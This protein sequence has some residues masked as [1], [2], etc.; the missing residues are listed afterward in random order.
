MAIHPFRTN[1]SATADASGQRTVPVVRLLLAGFLLAGC[2]IISAPVARASAQDAPGKVATLRR[3]A[4]SLA[5]T[6]R[7]HRAASA[8]YLQLGLALESTENIRPA[9]AAYREG[10][11][12]AERARDTLALAD[13]EH[14]VGLL[15]WRTNLYDSALVHLE[16][17]KRYRVARN[18]QRGLSAEYNSIGA[19][20]Y[21]LGVYEPA[22]EA[23]LE[24]LRMRRAE[25][26]SA[27]VSR[28]LAN[29]GKTYHDWGQLARARDVLQLAVAAGRS[30][31]SVTA[32]GYALNSLAMLEIDRGNFAAARALIEESIA[33]YETPGGLPLRADT[34]DAW[35]LNASARAHLMVREGAAAAALPLLDSVLQAGAD[36]GSIRGQ[37]R[38][39]LYQAE[40][41]AAMGHQA[42]ARNLYLEALRLARSVVQRVL[43]LNSLERLAVLEEAAG[44]SALALR[45]LREYQALGDTI[46]D[47]AAAQRIA[48][49][50]AREETQEAREANARLQAS[51]AAQAAVIARQQLV[52]GLGALI[53]VLVAALLVALITYNRR[54]RARLAVLSRT[55]GELAQTN[56]ELAEALTEVRT[57]S[58]LIPICAS[59]KNI[60]DD[61]GYWASVESYL[62]RRSN[63]TFSHGICQSC[64]PQL[65]GPLWKDGQPAEDGSP[66]T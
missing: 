6:G 9:L 4:D 56:G 29:I 62:A 58:G 13:I 66:I 17:A 2:A 26:D 61:Q 32:S 15:Y 1:R 51:Q 3:Q 14:R 25:G 5:G 48:S 52:V 24:A 44:N 36:R 53:L 30:S 65:Y 8:A 59:C 20:Y 28:T 39:L 21:Q 38:T 16:V 55:N 64:G 18:D 31:K 49:M 50:E 41:H 45:Y 34:V 35:A 60:R 11:R 37:A 46:F 22:L 23:F 40:A 54:D 42:V 12:L 7:D 63:V 10:H 47:Q 33:V 19:S 43:A 57:L 27:G